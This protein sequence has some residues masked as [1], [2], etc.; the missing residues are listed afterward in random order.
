MAGSGVVIS[1]A[2]GVTV[3]ELRAGALVDGPQ[4]EQVGKELLALVDEQAVRKLIVDFRHVGF[5]SST[6]IGALLQLH[7]H[8]AEIKGQVFLV[9]VSPKLMEVFKI[10]RLH[11][12]LH[13]A[14]DQNEAIRKMGV[15][16]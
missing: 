2:Q 11:K 1:S 15:I 10:T 4:I 16:G 12:V 13:F 6:M 14:K 9:G 5:L 3:A 7:K 8:A